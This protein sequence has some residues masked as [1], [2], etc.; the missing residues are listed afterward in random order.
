MATGSA[1]RR[2]DVTGPFEHSKSR[3]DKAGASVRAYI[4]AD[5]TD[6]V[7][8]TE[9]LLIVESFRRTHERAMGSVERSLRGLA[10]GRSD[11]AIVSRLKRLRQIAL[12]LS[13]KP[14]MRLSAM[15][16]VAGCRI[17]APRGELDVLQQRIGTEL[18]V[19]HVD[20]RRADPPSSGYRA[21]HMIVL[22][23][24]VRVEVQLRTPEENAWAALVEDLSRRPDTRLLKFG[25]GPERVLEVLAQVS[26]QLSEGTLRV[27]DLVD[28]RR[29]VEWFLDAE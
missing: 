2:E 6:A 1:R 8:S 3:I 16:D 4:V 18:Q 27:E 12:K 22:D 26:R 13:L 15:S 21:V 28:M 20:D 19:H 9:D 24:G 14:S 11:V 17:V 10:A 7:I 23:D 5:D 25:I 29:I